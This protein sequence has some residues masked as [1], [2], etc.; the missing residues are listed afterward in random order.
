MQSNIIL[1]TVLANIHRATT[2]QVVLS[3]LRGIIPRSLTT[4]YS[5][6]YDYPSTGQIPFLQR[7]KLWCRTVKEVTKSIA[8]SQPDQW[9]LDF[10]PQAQ[11]AIK[12]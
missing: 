11:P 1:T 10:G 9:S 2:D 12:R 8:V 3:V 5:G 4:T 6:R 7:R